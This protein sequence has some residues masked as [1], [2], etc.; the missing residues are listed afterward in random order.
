MTASHRDVV[1]SHHLS[2]RARDGFRARPHPDVRATASTAS[3]ASTAA[4]AAPASACCLGGGI[5]VPHH[6]LHRRHLLA[7]VR[8]VSAVPPSPTSVGAAAAAVDGLVLHGAQTLVTLAAHR[9]VPALDWAEKHLAL[10]AASLALARET[11][12]AVVP[13]V[14]RR[15]PSRQG[16][17]LLVSTIAR[18]E[19][20][21]AT[22]ATPAAAPAAAPA[23]PASQ[24]A[25]PGM[26][27]GGKWRV[28][29]ASAAPAAP[30]RATRVARLLGVRDR[31]VEVHFHR[32]VA[33]LVGRWAADVRSRESRIPSRRVP[34]HAR[35]SRREARFAS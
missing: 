23:Q 29:T 7:A 18:A 19:A 11:V 34:S 9:R 27:P 35:V 32:V 3:T 31:V 2:T 16:G 21:A 30:L 24:I 6:R 22:A 13:G 1:T 5:H 25:G 12:L 33:H 8:V 15:R 28:G 10:H 20:P 17:R 14:P 26:G 4:P